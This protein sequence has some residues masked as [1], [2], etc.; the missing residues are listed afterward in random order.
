MRANLEVSPGSPEHTA[1]EEFLQ[2]GAPFEDQQPVASAHSQTP[3]IQG[4]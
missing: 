3:T 4:L 2:F 1:V